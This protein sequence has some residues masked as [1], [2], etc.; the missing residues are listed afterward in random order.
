MEWVKN[1]E[2]WIKALNIGDKV[3]TLE[4]NFKWASVVIS[5]ELNYIETKFMRDYNNEELILL[6]KN[7]A[8]NHRTFSTNF[9]KN[10]FGPDGSINIEKI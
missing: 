7:L 8:P 3:L 6:T 9:V 2:E 1:N 5:I 10:Y 4:R